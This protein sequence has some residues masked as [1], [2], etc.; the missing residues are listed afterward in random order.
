MPP[1]HLPTTTPNV[2]EIV[3]PKGTHHGNDT[4]V[5]PASNVYISGREQRSLDPIDK[6]KRVETAY[7]EELDQ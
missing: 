2:C 4:Y 1:S 5:P 3:W 6:D 7:T